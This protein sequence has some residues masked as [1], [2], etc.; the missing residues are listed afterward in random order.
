MEKKMILYKA[1][2]VVIF[3]KIII[4]FINSI[5]H[6]VIKHGPT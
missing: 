2:V 6:F 4:I 5:L 1:D 3:K